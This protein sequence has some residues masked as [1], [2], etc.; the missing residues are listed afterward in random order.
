MNVTLEEILAGS[1]PNQLDRSFG[2]TLH[3]MFPNDHPLEVEIGA[4]KGRFLL[5]RAAANPDINFVGI[6]YVWKFMKIG[7]VRAQKRDMKNLLMF[8]AEATE[9]V[10]NLIPDE[11]VSM[12]H[13]YFPDPWH[14]K[15]HNKRRLLTPDFFQLLHRRLKPG[16]RLQLATDNFDYMIMF[17][18]SLIEAGTSLWSDSREAV[19]ERIQN[20]ELCTNFEL[21]YDIEGRDLYYFEFTK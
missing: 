13:V 18:S 20:P 11:S 7:W 16:G 12:F 2:G 3:D 17:R 21:K 6:D 19:N 9:V 10:N 8:K 5:G 4:G 1:G 15:R 14:K